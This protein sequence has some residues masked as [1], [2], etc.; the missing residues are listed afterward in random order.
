MFT[1]AADYAMLFGLATVFDAAV[2]ALKYM[3]P[4]DRSRDARP[5]SLASVDGWPSFA[6]GD[7]SHIR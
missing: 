2:F 7:D 3:R 1:K 6:P 5:E 4:A